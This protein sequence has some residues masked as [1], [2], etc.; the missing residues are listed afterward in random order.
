MNIYMQTL[1]RYGYDT[2]HGHYLT[3][4]TKE[5]YFLRLLYFLFMCLCYKV[6]VISQKWLVFFTWI[7]MI[8]WL[9]FKIFC[10]QIRPNTWS[11]WAKIQSMYIS[12][13]PKIFSLMPNHNTLYAGWSLGR[14]GAL[15]RNPYDWC[16]LS[17]CNRPL[18]KWKN[19]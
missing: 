10:G 4:I 13:W 6:F 7:W 9:L 18:E 3:L 11:T 19:L 8:Y 1:N 2:W 5:R 12:F 17:S 15:E 16:G 14:K